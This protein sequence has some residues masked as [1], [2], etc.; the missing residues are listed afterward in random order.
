MDVST[1]SADATL[2]DTHRIFWHNWKNFQILNTQQGRKERLLPNIKWENEKS[3]SA[4]YLNQLLTQIVYHAVEKGAR[5]INF[6]FS[7][8]TAFGPDAKKQFCGRVKSIVDSLASES[9]LALT[10]DEEHNLLTESIAAAYYFD[11][12]NPLQKLIFCVDIGGGSTDASIWME[13]KNIFQT[14]I[15]YASRDMFIR[16]LSRLVNM[17]TVLKA[18][19]TESIDDGIYQ[20]L[21]DVT[22]GRDMNDEKFKFLIETVLFEYYK[23]LRNR[24]E[25]LKGKDEEAFKNFKYCLFIAYSGLVYY[26]ANIISSLF[27]SKDEKRK[28]DNDIPELVIGLSGKGSKLTDWIACD[29]IY[30]EAE[31]LIE[32]KTGLEI[33][34]IPM[35]TSKTAKTETAIGMICKLDAGGMPK[36]Q[37]ALIEPDIFM[38]CAVTVNNGN[39]KKPLSETSFIDTYND[40]FFAEPASLKVEFSKDLEELDDFISF[41][42]K[43]SGKSRGDYPPINTEF[44][45]KSKKNLWS[46]IDKESKNVLKEG[47]FEPPFILMLKVFLEEYAEEYLWKKLA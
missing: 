27:V 47:R 21:S 29:V 25:N 14:S 24:L 39:E 41:L 34:I 42:N 5:S 23:K 36:N 4:K 7:Y 33:R 44:F 22:S 43:I 12:K 15:H 6:F 11:S 13:G 26:L 38:G 45:N 16:A 31:K 17:P 9:G 10:F 35:F 8:P 30:S 46:K 37:A 1:T 40:Q 28:I 32:E 19:T 20:M 2:F 3:H 18:V